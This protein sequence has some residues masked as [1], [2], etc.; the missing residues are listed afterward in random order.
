MKQTDSQTPKYDPN[1]ETT[2]CVQDQPSAKL[3]N[4]G[5]KAMTDTELLAVLLRGVPNSTDVARRLYAKADNNLTTLSH[6]SVEQLVTSVGITAR[7]A[8]AIKAAFELGK[9]LAQE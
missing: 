9:R 3:A 4:M 1:R 6:F 7:R 2:W 5:A 8:T